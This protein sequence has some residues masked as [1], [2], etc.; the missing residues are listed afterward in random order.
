MKRKR[1]IAALILLLTMSVTAVSCS[2]RDASGSENHSVGDGGDISAVDTVNNDD[3]DDAVTETQVADSMP[4]ASP[5]S[6]GDAA[7]VGDA[8]AVDLPQT[9]MQ[10]EAEPDRAI[11][12]L[13]AGDNVIHPCI[14]LEAKQRA[15][16]NTREYH[17]TP[18]YADV[19]D[20]IG[21]YD[22][23]F[24]NQE[25]L[26]GGADLGYVGYPRFNSPQ[27]LGL[28]LV[29]MGFDIVNIAN[30]H[31]ADQWEKGLKGTIEFWRNQP[32][33]LI[34]DVMN[35]DEYEVPDIIERDG[36]SIA[37]LSYTYGTNGLTLPASSEL[38]V[39]YIDDATILRHIENAK[40]LADLVF[41]SMH[42]GEENISKPTSEQVRV[43][44]LMADAGVDVIIGH[45]PHVLQPIE[46]LDGVNGNRTLCIY[47]LGNLVSAM[48]YSQNMVGGFVTFDVISKGGAKPYV[49][50]VKFLPTVFFYGM[51]YYS[52]HLYKMEDYTDAMAAKHGTQIYNNYAS[53]A[54]MRKF[55]TD[56]ISPEYLPD[57]IKST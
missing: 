54:Q 44:Q 31:M 41:V 33:T 9:G 16:A 57:W 55:V 51:N 13:T 46:W 20:I 17:F 39:P 45:H 40:T 6:V 42:W 2:F 19:V 18:M 53:S 56:I 7:D 12:F 52:T 21:S 27:D 22:V 14:Y 23:A 15:T 11:S 8:A 32:V 25:T 24:I 30:N 47:S 10:R 37:F 38:I 5:S 4:E 49:D 48:M 35:K 36:I 43:G 26:M 28:D 50:N 3:T 1:Q 29:E 34:G